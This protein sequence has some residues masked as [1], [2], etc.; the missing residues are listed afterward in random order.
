MFS[1]RI[2]FLLWV[3]GVPLLL[4]VAGC[5][6]GQPAAST[7]SPTTLA[8]FT[9]TPA[10]VATTAVPTPT[11]TP[12]P[13]AIRV[14]GEGITEAVYQA[15]LR[16]LQ[17]A[18]Q[19]LGKEL[20]ADQQRQQVLDNLTDTLLLAQGAAENGFQVDD[21][22]LQAEIERMGGA[23]AV[24]EWMNQHGYPESGFRE[25]LKRQMTAAWQRDQLIADVPS[26]A[27][28]VHVRQILTL[29]ENIAYR[30]LEY[31][32]IPGT[33]FSAYALQYDPVAGG[34]LGWFP[35]G[36]LTQTAVEEAAFS[37]QPGEIS[38]VVKSE[39]GFHIVQ[40]IAREPAR[41]ISPDARR[42]LQHKALQAWLETRRAA[43][44]IEIL[45]P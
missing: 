8:T 25:A 30:A 16:L 29:D 6:A 10:P 37:L 22:A 20:P 18:L 7:A 33:N 34:D 27:E 45:L 15:E 35:R 19:S 44:S 28:Q 31:V 38:Q 36:Y 14:N 3:A 26:Q 43:S 41:T 5:R 17:E 13:L 23:Q 32:K 39:I 2:Q 42:V 4:L 9:L 1:K 11:L 12:E 24:Q 21:A 40:V